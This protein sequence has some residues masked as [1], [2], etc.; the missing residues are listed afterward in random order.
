M[1]TARKQPSEQPVRGI[2]LR[3]A[4]CSF[5]AEY[6]LACIRPS[7]PAKPS[8]TKDLQK[9]WRYIEWNPNAT[10]GRDQNY[11]VSKID[12]AASQSAV[13]TDSYARPFKPSPPL[14]MKPENLSA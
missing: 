8:I 7:G 12:S 13:G 4:W 2:A 3:C 1:A 10:C 14:W 5:R 9:G 6:T 11:N